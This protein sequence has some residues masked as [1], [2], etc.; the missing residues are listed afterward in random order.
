MTPAAAH[1]LYIVY[2]TLLIIPIIHWT[3]YFT[4]AFCCV[5][6]NQLTYHPFIIFFSLYRESSHKSRR[7]RHL[8]TVHNKEQPSQHPPFSIY[9]FPS[10]GVCILIGFIKIFS[11]YSPHHWTAAF[12]AL[13]KMQNEKYNHNSTAARELF[14]LVRNHLWRFMG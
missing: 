3:C 13:F 11:S 9:L 14:F 8:Y 7:F 2:T 1:T 5:Q 6:C 4:C 12:T 10:P